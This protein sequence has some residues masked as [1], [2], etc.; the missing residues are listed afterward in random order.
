MDCPTF[1]KEVI[2]GFKDNKAQLYG[3]IGKGLLTKDIYIFEKS[4]ET[5]LGAEIDALRDYILQHYKVDK[6]K[7]KIKF[8]EFQ[9]IIQQWV[10]FESQRK[11]RQL[12]EIS[13]PSRQISKRTARDLEVTEVDSEAEAHVNEAKEKF[14][15]IIQ[16]KI[17]KHFEKIR[18]IFQMHS[19]E[20]Q[21]KLA[22]ERLNLK[23]KQEEVKPKPVSV[24]SKKTIK[25]DAQASEDESEGSE[26]SKSEEDAKTNKSK[27]AK[28]SH[29]NEDLDNAIVI[30][31]AQSMAKAE[32]KVKLSKMDRVL[33]DIAYLTGLGILTAEEAKS[34]QNFKRSSAQGI[35]EFIHFIWLK[36]HLDDLEIKRLKRGDKPSLKAPSKEFKAASQKSGGDKDSESEEESGS[37]DTHKHDDKKQEKDAKKKD[38]KKD[39]KAIPKEDKTKE[40]KPKESKPKKDE[41]SAAKKPGNPRDLIELAYCMLQF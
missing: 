33:N 3:L 29:R 27:T 31:Q 28:S 14:K 19:D 15:K 37:E 4:A 20:Y 1:A 36:K 9:R 17:E 21:A 8:N 22:Q 5:V 38:D 39:T 16:M 32:T 2:E 12:D 7:Y 10:E 25:S 6:D 35:D 23:A 13:Q 24:K 34:A 41:K 30:P 11:E 18:E 40:Q 26:K